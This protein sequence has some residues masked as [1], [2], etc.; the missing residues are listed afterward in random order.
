VVPSVKTYVDFPF[1]PLLSALA[2]A[3]LGTSPLGEEA[4]DHVPTTKYRLA[5]TAPDGTRGE[6]FAWVSRRGVLMK[7]QGTVTLPN[8]HKTRIAMELSDVKETSLQSTL[9]A[10]PA[11]MQAL[12]FAALAPLLGGIIR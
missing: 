7:L 6:G 11:D 2:E 9:F 4:V 5:D 8:G 10:P 3:Q 1:P 12:P